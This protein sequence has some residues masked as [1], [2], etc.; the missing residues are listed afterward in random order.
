MI[1]INQESSM[2]DVIVT[3][4]NRV[5]DCARFATKKEA[6]EYSKILHR[7]WHFDIVMI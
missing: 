7:I 4:G 3:L 6:V 5:I 1:K 2:W